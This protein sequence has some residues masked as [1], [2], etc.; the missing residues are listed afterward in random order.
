MREPKFTEAEKLF[1]AV[2]RLIFLPNFE[3][4]IHIR[5]YASKQPF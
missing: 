4:R 2:L 1:T 5:D 3:P